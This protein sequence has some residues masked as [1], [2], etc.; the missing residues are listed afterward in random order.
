MISYTHDHFFF[1]AKFSFIYWEQ[2]TS[3][4]HH[5]HLIKIP[6]LSALVYTLQLY[7]YIFL[8]LPGGQLPATTTRTSPFNWPSSFLFFTWWKCCHLNSHFINLSPHWVLVTVAFLSLYLWTVWNSMFVDT[9]WSFGTH[10]DNS[11]CDW[12]PNISPEMFLQTGN[13]FALLFIE[14]VPKWYP[15]S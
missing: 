5:L 14:E 2:T 13:I 7:F 9:F 12:E 4:F 15:C 11:M 3:L 6:V 8:D 10:G 1:K